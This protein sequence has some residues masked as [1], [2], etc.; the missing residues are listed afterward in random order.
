MSQLPA[1]AGIILIDKP[2]GPTSMRVCAKIRASF[3]AGGAAKRLKVGHAGTLDPLA[4]GLLVVMVGAATRRC[5]ALMAGEK[6][7]LAE[8]DLARTSST[9]DAEGQIEPVD[10]PRP[11]TIE[12]LR[13][14]CDV[15]TGKILQRPPAF[16]AVHIGGRRAYALARRGET[17][18]LTPREVFVR[19][20]EIVSYAW[21]VAS[22]RVVC[23]KGVYIRSLARDLGPLLCAGGMLTALRRTRIGDFR[24]EDAVRLDALPPVLRQRDLAAINPGG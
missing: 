17:V 11:P 14:A 6:E 24:V 13:A 12:Q 1:P 15:L 21:P 23:G 9:D 4:T 5:D 19:A 10:V 7:Y 20:I 16:S 18:E 3:R 2:I 22:L 8:V